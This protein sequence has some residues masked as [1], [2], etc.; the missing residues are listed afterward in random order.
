MNEKSLAVAM[1]ELKEQIV[2]AINVSNIPIYLVKYALKDI[3]DEVIQIAD[4]QIENEINQYKAAQ[5]QSFEENQSVEENI[6]E[7][8]AETEIDE[9]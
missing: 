5:A 1:T 6:E 9:D 2:N 7:D 4:T 8:K 3:Y